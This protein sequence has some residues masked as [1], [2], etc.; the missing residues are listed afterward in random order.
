MMIVKKN[1]LKATAFILAMVVLPTSGQAQ[2]QKRTQTRRPATPAVVKRPKLPIEFVEEYNVG[3]TDE[4]NN[5]S[6]YA[7]FIWNRTDSATHMPKLEEWV[8]IFPL[9]GAVS[10]EDDDMLTDNVEYVNIQGEV[11]EFLADYQRNM[12]T[13]YAI[14]LKS[15]DN[16]YRCAYRYKKNGSFR[17]DNNLTSG[18]EVSVIYLGPSF[19]G[20]LQTIANEQYWN[21][22]KSKIIRRYFPA[23]GYQSNS[24]NQMWGESITLKRGC[25]GYFWSDLMNESMVPTVMITGSGISQSMLR[26]DCL[27]PVRRFTNQ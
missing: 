23:S 27:L 1:F 5:T 17:D 19:K 16:L 2:Q 15:D 6:E 22:N 18:L 4:K 20:S 3:T 26:G 12:R 25:V 21:T 9:D 11:H 8:G 24:H 14:R 7:M 13:C 10:F